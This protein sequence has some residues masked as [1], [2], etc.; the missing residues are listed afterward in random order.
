M[1]TATVRE[2]AEIFLKAWD[3][4]LIEI[5]TG[6]LARTPIYK[7]ALSGPYQREFSSLKEVDKY[8][9]SYIKPV[10]ERFFR[11]NPSIR[12][13]NGEPQD[14]EIY[15]KYADRCPY[16]LKP[17]IVG[18]QEPSSPRI[19]V[20]R[21]IEGK[22]DIRQF[23]ESHP[24]IGSGSGLAEFIGEVINKWKDYQDLVLTLVERD[25]A[26]QALNQNGSG[27]AGTSADEIKPEPEGIIKSSVKL[28]LVRNGS[29][30]YWEDRYLPIRGKHFDILHK[31]AQRPGEIIIHQELYSLI[32]SQYHQDLLLRHYINS[33]RKAFPPPYNHPNH[34]EGIIK[35]RKMEGYYLN[36]STKQVKI[37]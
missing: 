32:H 2:Q 23:M 29:M 9:R 20:D 15:N 28:R 1:P 17:Y 33:I 13:G 34:P 31:L 36:L 22:Q 12:R 24:D 37:V 16:L 26:L 19:L 27:Q 10:V 4:Y 5:K 7:R 11:R 6:I 30:V 25:E 14:V 21:P 35:T 8:F 3:S 18:K